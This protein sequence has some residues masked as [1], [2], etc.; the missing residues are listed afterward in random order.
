MA[1]A[2][3]IVAG[4]AGEVAVITGGVA[5]VE[6]A[7]VA[8][9][10]TA[11]VAGRT[12]VAARRVGIIEKHPISSRVN[13]NRSNSCTLMLLRRMNSRY[14]SGYSDRMVSSVLTSNTG[15]SPVFPRMIRCL[16]QIHGTLS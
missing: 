10:E 6:T 5:G 4:V 16:T 8:G 9:V 13:G 7:G 15:I 1:V 2:G 3:V 11:G 12:E 14:C